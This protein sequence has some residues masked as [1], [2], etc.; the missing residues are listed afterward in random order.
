MTRQTSAPAG[1]CPARGCG[2]C[3]ACC[4]N[5]TFSDREKKLLERIEKVL[6]EVSD[7][8]WFELYIAQQNSPEDPCV[9]ALFELLSKF[10]YIGECD[11]NP[12]DLE[13]F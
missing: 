7:K 13:E 9:N 6:S 11:V 2:C 4:S 3:R 5:R 1:C 10:P 8:Y 12:N